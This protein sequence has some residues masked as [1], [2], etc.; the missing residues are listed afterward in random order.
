V[1]LQLCK[2]SMYER[3]KER[4]LYKASVRIVKRFVLF[5][6]TLR[7]DR[8]LLLAVPRQLIL[9]ILQAV[10]RAVL[11]PNVA[12]DR[13][14]L[15][16]ATVATLE[17]LL[18]RLSD[19]ATLLLVDDAVVGGVGVGRR[20]LRLTFDTV[21]LLELVAGGLGFGDP[22]ERKRGKGK[23]ERRR[24]EGERVSRRKKGRKG[25]R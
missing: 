8:L 22:V 24:Y 10:L 9:D 14:K 21:P 20:L 5:H 19:L 25:K 23:E 3:G 1:V 17:R 15:H 7:R 18:V 4:D 16:L 13:P 11:R 6:L 2:K 12:P